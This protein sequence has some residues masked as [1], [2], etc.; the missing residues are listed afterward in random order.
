MHIYKNLN[1]KKAIIDKTKLT[2]VTNIYL[3]LKSF[4]SSSFK[5]LDQAQVLMVIIIT[6]GAKSPKHTN[7]WTKHHLKIPIIDPS[8]IFLCSSL[9]NKSTKMV[10]IKTDD[11]YK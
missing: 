8:N 1:D 5:S 11:G 4:F 6:Y 2:N 10:L 7:M 9:R 3:N